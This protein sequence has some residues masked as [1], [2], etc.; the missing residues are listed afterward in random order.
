MKSALAFLTI[1]VLCASPAA[2]QTAKELKTKRGVS[3]PLVNLLNVR[4]GCTSSP[5]PVAIPVVREKP[6]NGTVQ[7][8][9]IVVDVAA[10]SNCSARKV[11]AVALLYSPKD[12]FIGT[13][14]VGIE[15]EMGNRT[16]IL[17]YNISVGAPGETL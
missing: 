14:S 17:N 2:G 3:I 16:T 10:S 12:N 7:M 5:G 4:Q 9:I 13:D 1:L 15:I 6:A 11:P 8:L